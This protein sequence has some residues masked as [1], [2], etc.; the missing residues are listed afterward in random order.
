MVN[1]PAGTSI[2]CDWSLRQIISMGHPELS[3]P[4]SATATNP[5]GKVRGATF[6]LTSV[7]PWGGGP[8]TLVAATIASFERSVDSVALPS[9]PAELERIPINDLFFTSAG[10][11]SA[12]CCD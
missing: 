12:G 2:M 7:E 5:S 10:G 6:V 1:S 11:D 8:V 4:D 3:T 9:D